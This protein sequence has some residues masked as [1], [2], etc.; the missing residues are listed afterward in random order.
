MQKVKGFKGD[1]GEKKVVGTK[2]SKSMFQAV[3]KPGQ[4]TGQL[5]ISGVLCLV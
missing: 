1:I 3:S 4:M 2:G 5:N